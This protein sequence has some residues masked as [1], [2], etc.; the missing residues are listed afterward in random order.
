MHLPLYFDDEIR[1]HARVH[2]HD[3]RHRFDRFGAA[4]VTIS[5]HA[6]MQML[7][8]SVGRQLAP[9]VDALAL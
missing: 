2:E 6:E 5:A 7:D 4:P 3:S 1:A 8:S 9:N